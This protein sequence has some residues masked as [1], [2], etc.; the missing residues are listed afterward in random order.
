MKNG[1]C[2]TVR[3]KFCSNSFPWLH[4][5]WGCDDVVIQ[6]CVS[7]MAAVGEIVCA[8]VLPV[9][10]MWQKA[11]TYLARKHL[12]SCIGPLE[13]CERWL[14]LR[15]KFSSCSPWIRVGGEFASILGYAEVVCHVVRP[16]WNLLNAMKNSKLWLWCRLGYH[17]GVAKI[18]E[19]CCKIP[20]GSTLKTI[21]NH[22]ENQRIE[23]KNFQLIWFFRFSRFNFLIY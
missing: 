16:S 3:I 18:M 19:R 10:S 12:R 15:Q 17:P 7:P 13:R 9:E 20:A 8:P 11:W 5:A 23:N 2:A 21:P 4:S 1:H 6:S 14:P 22:F